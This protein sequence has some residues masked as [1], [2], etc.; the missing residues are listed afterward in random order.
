MNYHSKVDNDMV[1][2]QTEHASYITEKTGNNIF[3]M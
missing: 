2:A 3:T 1:E